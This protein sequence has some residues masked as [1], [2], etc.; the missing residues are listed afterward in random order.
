MQGEESPG[1]SPDSSAGE[2]VDE[3]G[4][5]EQTLLQEAGKNKEVATFP[6]AVVSRA[7]TNLPMSLST[8]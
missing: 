3:A 5:F 8:N 6:A 4:S 1:Q 7:E 2:A